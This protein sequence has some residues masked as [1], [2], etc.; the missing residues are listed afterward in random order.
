MAHVRR[1]A[2]T[3][4]K[5]TVCGRETFEAISENAQGVEVDGQRGYLVDNKGEQ[6]D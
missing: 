6:N 1:S 2:P 4:H 5:T 3:D